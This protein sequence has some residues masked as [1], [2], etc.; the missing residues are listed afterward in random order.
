MNAERHMAE[1]WDAR[2]RE[3]AEYYVDNRLDY[4]RGDYGPDDPEDFW[5]KGVRAIE[6][7]LEQTRAPAIGPDDTVLDVGCGVGRLVRAVADRP[8][9]T[10]GLDVSDE[11]LRRARAHLGDR[12]GV[13]WVHGDGTSLR[14]VADA[15]VDVVLSLVVFQHI[16]DPEVTY[17]YVREIGR[18]L[19]PGGW[20]AFQVSDDPRVHAVAPVGRPSLRDRLLRRAAPQ[21]QDDP[22]WRGSA[23]DLERLDAEA[24]AA[25]LELGHR[26]GVGTQYC[27]VRYRRVA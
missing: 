22:A 13:E 4:R 25:G 10:I 20:A 12:P 5:A 11:M 16:P 6:T 24:S 21:G 18:V 2:A 1:F 15:S 17:G 3:N 14:P 8:G 7:L 27:L 19:R 23:V 26:T 9:R